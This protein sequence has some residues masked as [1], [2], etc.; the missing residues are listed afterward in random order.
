MHPV[1]RA[2]L[3]SGIAQTYLYNLGDENTA[4][5]GG[6][7]V[8][9]SQTQ[10]GA[11]GSQ[12]KEVDHL[13]LYAQGAA[14]DANAWI[15]YVTNNA[16]DLTNFSTMYIEW[17]VTHIGTVTNQSSAGVGTVKT[18]NGLLAYKFRQDTST[19]RAIE[20]FDVTS[21]S[22]GHYCKLYTFSA[23]SARNST[24]KAFRVWLE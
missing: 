4:V 10:S 17:D 9:A 12:N 11:S 19:V 24:V 16:I 3:Q 18:D 14:T 6:W 8:G 21:L 13:K 15:T 7:V 5:T 23:G 22:G 2:I 1:V 20:S